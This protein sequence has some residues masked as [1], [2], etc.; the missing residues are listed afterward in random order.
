MVAGISVAVVLIPQALAYAE[1]AGMPPVTGLYAAMLA[2]IVAAFFASSR[3]LQT[4]P[5]AMTSLLTFGVLSPLALPGGERYV[6][7]AALLALL[8]GVVRFGLGLARFGWVAFLLSHPVLLGFTSGGAVLIILSQ[9][10]TAVAAAAPDGSLVSRAWWVLGHPGAWEAT[11]V[12]LSAVTLLLVLG[13]RRIHPLFPGVLVALVGGLLFSVVSDYAGPVVGSMAAGLPPLTLDLPW[14]DLPALLV[15]GVVLALVGFAEPAAIA[16]TYAAQDRERW[17]ANRELVSQ[18]VANLAAGLS[19]GFPVGGSWSRTAIARLAG[20]RSRWSGAVTGV[21]VVA[22]LPLAPV[23]AAVP[24]AVLAAIILAA[25]I[26]LVRLRPLVGLVALSLPQAAVGWATFALTLLLAPRVDR[27]ILIGIGLAVL[28]H[29]WRERRV[30]VKARFEEGTLYLE[31]KGVLFFASA[32]TLYQA[33]MD[34]LAANPA[35]GRLVV[36]LRHLGR[37]D[38]TGAVALREL[39]SEA[40]SAGLEVELQQAPPQAWRLLKKVLAEPR[41]AS[42]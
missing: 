20:A 3:Y 5:V 38:I 19:G 10:P 26:N 4:G 22:L 29:V 18:G 24:R 7:L 31:P 40:E 17:D 23:L 39:V 32:P 34:E 36:D 37:I 21:V 1:L 33:F 15:P 8:V 2:P 12:G 27:A 30:H 42:D 11:A 14:R 28:V 16:R 13:G 25:V 9:I 35:T 41:P 6:A